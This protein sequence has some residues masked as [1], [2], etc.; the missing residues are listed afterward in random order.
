VDLYHARQH[1]WELARALYPSRVAKQK[2]WVTARQSKLD[3]GAIEKLVRYLRSLE[4][5]DPQLVDKVPGRGRLLR[6][7]RSTHALSE[8]P[9]AKAIRWFWCH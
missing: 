5:A 3:G 1:L 4:T 6:T 8:I 7:Q 9:R 2:R